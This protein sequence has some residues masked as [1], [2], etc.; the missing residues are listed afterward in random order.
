MHHL[1]R[2]Y[3]IICSLIT[4]T[5]GAVAQPARKTLHREEMDE[6]PYYF[7]LSLGYASATVVAEKSPRFLESDSIMVAEPVQSPGYSLRL[8]A[9]ARLTNRLE[10]RFNPGLI[11][12]VN[13]SFNYTLGSR[14]AY[15]EPTASKV[16]QS[17]I[18]T[19][20][21]HLKFNSDRIGNFKA[22]MLGGVKYDID[23]AS[24]AKASN[25]ED[26]IKFKRSDFGV[27]VGMGFNF[28][29]PFVTVSPE[30]KFSHGLTDIHARDENLK[31]SYVM[32]KLGSRMILFTIH[33]EK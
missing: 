22:Y 13:R 29:L 6:K 27:E 2:K 33:L 9:T 3:L 17:N 5:L 26:L 23:L 7:G 14:Q 30:I 21:F 1:L 16:V 10:L 4:C 12:G 11:L 19:M 18:A 28:Y 15:E 31:Y 20:P 8:L 32:D 25:A 24:N